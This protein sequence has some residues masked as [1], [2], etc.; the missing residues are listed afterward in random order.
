MEEDSGSSTAPPPLEDGLLRPTEAAPGSSF[1]AADS[2]PP[3]LQTSEA[4]QQSSTSE[5][6]LGLA[7]SSSPTNLASDTL[8]ASAMKQQSTP[9]SDTIMDSANGA[10]PYGTRSRNRTTARVNYAEEPDIDVDVDFSRSNNVDGP[11]RTYS[12]ESASLSPAIDEDRL[13]PPSAMKPSAAPPSNAST[14][15]YQSSSNKIPGTSTFSAVPG[16]GTG[17]VHSKKRKAAGNHG[18]SQ[19]TTA[20]VSQ[21]ISKKPKSVHPHHGP[22]ETN[23]LTFDNSGAQLVNESL[24]ADDGTSLSID[25]ESFHSSGTLFGSPL[26]TLNTLSPST[27]NSS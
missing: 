23:M 5:D 17:A 2:N 22:R 19:T 14:P 27:S 3:P 15:H 16:A 13:S 6:H 25:G 10:A 24:V 4:A 26:N 8:E 20:V 11:K 9:S 18:H 7:E 21:A 1:H 12:S